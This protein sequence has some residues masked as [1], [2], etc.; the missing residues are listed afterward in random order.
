M[1]LTS[2]IQESLWLQSFQNELK[3]G[4]E[5]QP[6]TICCDNMSALD[7]AQSNGYSART[8]I[9]IRHHFIRQHVEEKSVN[10]VHV[11]TEEM[12]ADV[13]TKALF[14]TKHLFCSRGL[15]MSF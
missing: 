14:G 4:D 3:I 13:L 5:T 15:G 7:L 10:L 8:N 11:S 1:S 9:D 2:T 6:I 12:L